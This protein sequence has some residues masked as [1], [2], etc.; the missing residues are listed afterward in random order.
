VLKI[1]HPPKWYSLFNGPTNLSELSRE[2]TLRE[3]HQVL[4]TGFSAEAHGLKSITD[5]SPSNRDTLI[6]EPIRKSETI[7]SN[8]PLHLARTFLTSSTYKIINR[9]LPHMLDEFKNFFITL[10]NE[11]IQ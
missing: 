1:K 5:L 6:L 2:T 3:A 10:L 11:E 4:Y 7:E 9:Y 8:V